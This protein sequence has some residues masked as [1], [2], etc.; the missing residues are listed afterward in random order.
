MQTR[1]VAGTPTAVFLSH[2]PVARRTSSLLS[3]S[4]QGSPRTPRS[5]GSPSNSV[6]VPPPPNRKSTDSWNSSNADDVEWEWSQDQLILLS[7]VT[8]LFFL[9]LSS[10][11]CQTLD[12]LPAHLVTPFNGPIPPSNLLDKI[13]RGVAHAKGPIDWPHSIRA[14]RVKL[15]ELSRLRAKEQAPAPHQPHSIAEEPEDAMQIEA[16]YSYSHDGRQKPLAIAPSATRP[17]Y[18]QSSM[19]FMLNAEETDKHNNEHLARFVW[20]PVSLHCHGLTFLPVSPVSCNPLSARMPINP[21]WSLLQPQAHPLSTPSPPSLYSAAISAGP[22]QP[23]LLHH[24]LSSAVAAMASVQT[25]E[26]SV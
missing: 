18:R 15:I 22:P 1:R 6:F 26:F 20:F 21:L 2:A 14:T 19:D 23:S 12:A 8:F 24:F 11:L 25:L 13:A 3:V 5:C 10:S 4:T 7:R 9:H 16:N 17:L